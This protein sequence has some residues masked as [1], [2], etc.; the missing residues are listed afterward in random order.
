M[1]QIHVKLQHSTELCMYPCHPPLA[2]SWHL[3]TAHRTLP[4]RSSTQYCNYLPQYQHLPT[5]CSSSSVHR[6]FGT[7]ASQDQKGK[8]LADSTEALLGVAFLAAG[9]TAGLRLLAKP[10]PN[11]LPGATAAASSSADVAGA[12]GEVW[13]EGALAAG[14][15]A[16]ASLAEAVDILLPGTAAKLLALTCTHM[17][18]NDA[19]TTTV[20]QGHDR[21][22]VCGEHPVQDAMEVDGWSAHLQPLDAATSTAASADMITVMP[23]TEQQQP[24]A[25]PTPA[26][27]P[28]AVPRAL[29]LP[30]TPYWAKRHR[31]AARAVGALLGGYTF[32]RPELAFQALCHCSYH[33]PPSNQVRL[34]SCVYVPGGLLLDL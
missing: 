17:E 21:R 7:P 16:A 8:R 32:N 23:A 2:C 27:P 22:V 20:V 10:A 24:P 18:C 28:P 30:I 33:R 29:Q 3:S 31:A 6:L 13:D 11:T 19:A 25:T 9:G 12:V 15:A 34:T 4:S 1:A 14:L 26:M 5:T